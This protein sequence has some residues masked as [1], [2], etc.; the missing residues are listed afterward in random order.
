MAYSEAW[1]AVD[2]TSYLLVTV[3][4]ITGRYYTVQFL[5]GWGETLANINE[6]LFPDRPFGEFAV[7]LKGSKVEIL[8]GARR[9]DLPVKY[10]RVLLRCR[11][12]RGS[13]R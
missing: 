3:P 6:R 2:E 5:N 11:Q 4:K 10:S 8:P 13:G 1:V 9:I 12:S 7:C